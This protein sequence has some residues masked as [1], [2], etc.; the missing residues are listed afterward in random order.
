M[1][2]VLDVVLKALEIV[3]LFLICAAVM[4][5]KQAFESWDPENWNVDQKA[6]TYKKPSFTF[7][8]EV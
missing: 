3:S 4:D 2:E 6:E 8:M 5:L 7:D 1:F